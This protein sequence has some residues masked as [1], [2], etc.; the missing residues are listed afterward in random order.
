M[1]VKKEENSERKGRLGG[2]VGRLTNKHK[3]DYAK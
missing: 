1:G 3:L 2:G